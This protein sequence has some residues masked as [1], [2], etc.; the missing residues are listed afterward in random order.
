MDLVFVH[1]SGYSDIDGA[2]ESS[3]ESND[4]NEDEGDWGHVELSGSDAGK[5]S[6]S[7]CCTIPV[8][9]DQPCVE[10]VCFLL[11]RSMIAD[12]L[13][14]KVPGPVTHSRSRLKCSVFVHSS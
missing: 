1:E 8:D 9:G 10:K 3:E 6:P 11:S 14:F 2:S 13:F 5:C 7:R 12:S 4:E